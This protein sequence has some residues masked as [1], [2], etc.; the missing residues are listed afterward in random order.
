MVRPDPIGSFTPHD[1]KVAYLGWSGDEVDLMPRPLNFG[2]FHDHLEWQRADVVLLCFGLN[3]SFA[4]DAGLPAWRK[5]LTGFLEGL[6]QKQFNGK[7]PPRRVLIS[8]IAHEDLGAP[9]PTGDAVAQRNRLLE[10]YTRVMKEVAVEKKV[11]F[12]DLFTPTR[13]LMARST[14]TPLTLNGIHLTERGYHLVSRFLAVQLGLVSE[15]GEARDIDGQGAAR[16][17]RA[18]EL[19][20]QV[21]EK[22]HLFFLFWR[23]LNPFYVWGGRAYCWKKDEPMVELERIAEMIDQ[24]EQRIWK[25]ATLPPEAVWGITPRGAEIWEAPVDHTLDPSLLGSPPPR[26]DAVR[27]NG[28][29]R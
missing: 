28:V 10:A 21:Y 11:R 5:R 22:N 24:R 1:V 25:A 9:L 23:P 7:E 26:L 3:E 19:R 6:E 15:S 13:D 29:I 2:S 20:R 16:A 18:Q 27:R 12:V 14:T 4:G 8:P 17:A